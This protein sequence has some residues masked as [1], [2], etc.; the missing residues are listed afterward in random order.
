[1]SLEPE[2]EVWRFREKV[3]ELQTKIVSLENCIEF[4]RTLHKECVFQRGGDEWDG[5]VVLYI[6]R[7]RLQQHKL[8]YYQ[9][10]PYANS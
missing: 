5:M 8:R 10:N 3:N 4:I 2:S 1:M 7:Y 6:R 9:A